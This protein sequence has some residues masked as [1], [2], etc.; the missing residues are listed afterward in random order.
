MLCSVLQNSKE[1]KTKRRWE[2]LVMYSSLW[3]NSLVPFLLQIQSYRTPPFVKYQKTRIVLRT[4]LPKYILNGD[5]SLIFKYLWRRL[6]LYGWNVSSLQSLFQGIEWLALFVEDFSAYWL[7]SCL[8]NKGSPMVNSCE[9]VSLGI[10]GMC[11]D[12]SRVDVATAV[13]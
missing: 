8:R 12:P 7:M 2:V 4:H 9:L 13:S 10:M 5:V 11:Y 3:K 1:G 6:L